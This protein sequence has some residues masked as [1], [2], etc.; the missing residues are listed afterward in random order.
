MRE[1]KEGAGESFPF[2]CTRKNTP[3]NPKNIPLYQ[4]A[5]SLD[6]GNGRYGNTGK[7]G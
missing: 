4:S 3:L 2:R 5:D 6:L 7:S 1:N